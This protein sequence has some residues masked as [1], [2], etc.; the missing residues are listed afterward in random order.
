MEIEDIHPFGIVL[1]VYE[2]HVH[3]FNHIS[4]EKLVWITRNLKDFLPGFV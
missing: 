3:P 4:S 2:G 1:C